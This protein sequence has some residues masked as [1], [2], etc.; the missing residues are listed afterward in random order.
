VDLVSFQRDRKTDPL[1]PSRPSL[2]KQGGWLIVA[3]ILV[4]AVVHFGSYINLS[5]FAPPPSSSTFA[6]NQK[7]T[8]KVR[9]VTTPKQTAPEKTQNQPD[10]A[11]RQQRIVE[12]PLEPTE[13]PTVPSFLGAQDHIA[14][15]ETKVSDRKKRPRAEEAGQELGKKGLQTQAAQA[16][17]EKRLLLR[18]GPV[19]AQV[20]MDKAK[21][22]NRYESL[23]PTSKDLEGQLRAGFQDYI[24]EKMDEGDRID[25]NTTEYRF[26]GYFSQM[27]RAIEL[28]WT[29]PMDAARRGMQG[30]VGLEFTINKDGTTSRIRVI[31]SSGY[32]IL[33]KAIVQAIKLASPFSPLPPN[34]GKEKLVVTG[35]FR[36]VLT[37]FAGAH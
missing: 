3:A 37:S 31:R 30:E 18:N 17:K 22:R 8:V 10:P 11:E 36:Y 34:F 33:D 15:K 28:V 4:S 13:K 19:Q 2:P 24:G 20:G 9:I 26:I 16:A 1:A 5:R 32:E 14:K 35:S 23:L 6:A 7:K 27:R 29:Y 21:P 25:I 12:T